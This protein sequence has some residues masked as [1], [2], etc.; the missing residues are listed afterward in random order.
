MVVSETTGHSPS[1]IS[2]ARIV[3]ACSQHTTAEGETVIENSACDTSGARVTGFAVKTVADV[4]LQQS[5]SVMGSVS[6]GERSM[7]M[8]TENFWPGFA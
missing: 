3:S 1:F 5:S 7:L 2:V 6:I 8:A 4:A